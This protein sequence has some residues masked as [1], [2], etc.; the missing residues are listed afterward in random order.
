[1]ILRNVNHPRV[2]VSH[3][4]PKVETGLSSLKSKSINSMD[5]SIGKRVLLNDKRVGTV[6]FIGETQFASGICYQQMS[7]SEPNSCD[8]RHFHRH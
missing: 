7:Y 1:M 8:F 4:T 2:D 5:I 6:R 3:V